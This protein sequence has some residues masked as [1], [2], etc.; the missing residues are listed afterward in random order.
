MYLPMVG[1][2]SKMQPFGYYL[3]IPK[4][5]E[6]LL[7]TL[8]G[9]CCTIFDASL[10]DLNSNLHKV[11][12]IAL[13]PTKVSGNTQIYLKYLLSG[14]ILVR[15]FSVHL[16]L[17]FYIVMLWPAIF[18]ERPALLLPW[19]MVGAIKCLGMGLLSFC[20]GLF[21]CVSYG[22]YRPACVDFVLAQVID[23]MP[24]FYMWFCVLS[25][26]RE[27]K[28]C[29]TSLSY[30]SSKSDFDSELTVR[31]RRV[32][33]MADNVVLKHQ[34]HH[35][36][37]DEDR[38][39][40]SVSTI[41]NIVQQLTTDLHRKTTRSLDS[42]LGVMAAEAEKEEI[43]N[44]GDDLPSEEVGLTIQEKTAKLLKLTEADILEAQQKRKTMVFTDS[45]VNI[46]GNLDKINQ[47]EKTAKI[48]RTTDITV[49]SPARTNNILRPTKSEKGDIRKS[50]YS[51]SNAATIFMSDVS[52]TEIGSVLNYSST[53]LTTSSI[54]EENIRSII[55]EDIL[56]YIE[57]QPVLLKDSDLSVSKIDKEDISLKEPHAI[58][59]NE[60]PPERQKSDFECQ[61]S[62][63]S[64]S[65]L[66]SYTSDLEHLTGNWKSTDTYKRVSPRTALTKPSGN[67]NSTGSNTKLVENYK[68]LVEKDLKEIQ[69]IMPAKATEGPK[70]ASSFKMD[71]YTMAY[72]EKMMKA[73]NQ[74]TVKRNVKDIKQQN[75]AI[76]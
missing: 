37:I 12:E 59:K 13:D 22:L 28:L 50:D 76:D 19:L 58:V 49:T 7:L 73:K 26:Y 43:M 11:W 10:L 32:R 60:M 54:D 48:L 66:R 15:T 46:D 65:V 57:E 5:T 62:T 4:Q 31:R 36:I 69:E 29:A 63:L 75:S 45:M 2:V 56:P 33:S 18:E 21:T 39:L 17:A 9:I 64:R 23:H 44:L 47:G 20:T 30:E 41:E 55:E 3:G 1:C 34:Y 40:I 53:S 42:L 25:Y 6:V 70:Y 67:D 24:S 51:K 74:K 72:N 61:A 8:I 14:I 27:L 68:K 52:E 38:H 35:Q 16:Y 71:G